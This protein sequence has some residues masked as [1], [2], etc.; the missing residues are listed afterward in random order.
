[1]R[2]ISHWVVLTL[3]AWAL[4]LMNGC[5]QRSYAQERVNTTERLRDR[6]D[7]RQDR[8]QIADDRRDLELLKQWA[9]ELDAAQKS[10]DE[11]AVA[12][13]DAELGAFLQAELGESNV[14][15]AQAQQEVREDRREL[16]SD[17]RE[18]R[19]NQEDDA[20]AWERADDRHDLRDDRRDRRDDRRDAAQQRADRAAKVEMAAELKALAGHY[21]AESLQ[22]RVVLVDRLRLLAQAEMGENREELREDRREL[23]EDRRETREDRREGGD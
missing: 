20:T 11:K 22:A 21:D 23:R 10:G 12:G 19:D 15:V 6:Q 5:A 1:M 2:N 9:L 3:S 8:R 17:R 14:E 16:R 4:P 7:L 18:I 13:L